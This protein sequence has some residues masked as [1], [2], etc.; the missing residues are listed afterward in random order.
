MI[1]LSKSPSISEFKKEILSRD[2]IEKYRLILGKRIVIEK[3][4]IN[5]P[6]RVCLIYLTISLKLV[7]LYESKKQPIKKP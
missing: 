6:I 2:E 5:K 3:E 7:Y 1:A 4:K